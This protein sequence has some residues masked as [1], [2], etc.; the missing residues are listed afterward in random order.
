[1]T[2]NSVTSTITKTTFA[3]NSTITADNVTSTT[4][5][6]VELTSNVTDKETLYKD[7]SQPLKDRNDS[8]E[9]RVQDTTLLKDNKIEKCVLF[10]NNDELDVFS[11]KKEI[12]IKDPATWSAD[13]ITQQVKYEIVK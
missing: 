3:D 11:K 6:Q 10:S 8:V 12:D 5:T 9:D 13:K 4:T 7:I 2:T 1:V